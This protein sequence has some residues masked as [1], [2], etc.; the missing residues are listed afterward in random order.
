MNLLGNGLS[1]IWNSLCHL[2]DKTFIYEI[3]VTQDFNYLNSETLFLYLSLISM[4]HGHCSVS[5]SLNKQTTI[6][7]RHSQELSI[8]V[9]IQTLVLWLEK[10]RDVRDRENSVVLDK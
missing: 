9:M 1:C 10:D 2:Q 3:N 6:S 7:V 4:I 5:Q 8:A